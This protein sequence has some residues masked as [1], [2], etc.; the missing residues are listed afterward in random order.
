MMDRDG[1]GRAFDRYL[2][3][4]EACDFVDR[5]RAEFDKY[6]LVKNTASSVYI[7]ALAILSDE[8]Q[9]VVHDRI[10]EWARSV[11]GFAPRSEL[12]SSES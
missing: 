1:V 3:L 9:C 6:V 12:D 4:I 10:G 8:D 5:A 2:E 7:K 11:P